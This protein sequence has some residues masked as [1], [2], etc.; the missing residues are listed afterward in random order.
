MA[1]VAGTAFTRQDLCRYSVNPYQLASIDEVELRDGRARGMKAYRVRSQSGLVFDLHAGRALDIGALS[2][3]GQNISLLTRNGVCSPENIFPSGGEFDRYFG[4][5]MLWTCGLKNAGPNYLD[6]A[7]Q[8]QPLH[9]R[10]GTIPPE[11][12]WKKAYFE[13]DEYWLEA[14]AVLRDT[15]LEG[16]NLTLT[17]TVRTALSRPEIEI[18]DMIENVDYRPT[19][20]LLLYHFNFGFPF[21]SENLKL[22]FPPA[23]EPV[24]P[25]NETARQHLVEWREMTA[26][27]DGE[28]ENVFF[29]TPE[30]APDGTAAV[31]LSNPALGIGA[32][33]TYETR[34]LPYLIQWKCMRSGE[35]AL[36]IE[37]G[38]NLISSLPNE[39]AAGRGAILNPFE[40]H[41]VRLKLSFHDL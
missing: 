12:V 31:E 7:G 36:G 29:H 41:E 39:R 11:Q 8:F 3:K 21:L 22:D 16:H 10:I 34:H 37:P 38:N 18:S 1:V 13:G 33:L 20:Y 6:E 35:Y 14:G 32:W 23:R 19:D 24:Q 25:R 28:E 4:G 27:V 2:Y 5:G 15:T 30:S 9:G 26:P 40:R 17:R